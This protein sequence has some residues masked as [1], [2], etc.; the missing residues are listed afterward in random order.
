VD[1]ENKNLEWKESWHDKYLHTSNAFA[2]TSGG[3]LEIGRR[4]DGLIAGLIDDGGY[5]KRAML[6]L[7][8]Q[9]PEKWFFGGYVKV[10]FFESS[11]PICSSKMKSMAL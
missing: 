8:H 3:I 11:A 5:I 6:L 1:L 4:E 9:D 10:G 2:N 7:S